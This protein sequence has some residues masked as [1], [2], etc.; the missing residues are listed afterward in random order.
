[1][2]KKEHLKSNVRKLAIKA[3]E[4]NTQEET[5]KI[6]NV[7]R[8]TIL[9]WKKKSETQDSLERKVGSGRSTIF[10][11]EKSTWLMSL[12]L[13]NATNHGFETD[14]WTTSRICQVYKK[15]FKEII[16][17]DT[18]QIVLKKLGFTYHKPEKRYYDNDELQ[19]KKNEWLENKLVLIHETASK[20]NAVVYY[21][22]EANISLSPVIGK[23]WAMKGTTPTISVTKNRGSI[24]AISAINSTGKLLFKLYDKKIT[25]IEIIYFLNQ[26]LDHHKK[27]HIVV[28]MD[29]A[30]SHK[31]K[32]VNA[33][34]ESQKR[35]HVIY[36]SP[37]SPEFN[38]DEKVWNHLKNHELK[39]H[40]AKTKGELKKLTKRKLENMAKNKNLVKGIFKRCYVA[41][42][43]R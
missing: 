25:S 39:A 32:K 38:P 10:N 14:L 37:Y 35:L 1:M 30:T 41:N 26:I 33:F 40:R 8:Y 19:K 17:D 12:V 42:I 36:F 22:D 2:K 11:E 24:S 13:S 29:N 20:Y 4:N 23:T 27:R 5:A 21:E 16:S 3:L 6:F 28:V 18:I 43:L 15:D 9:R 34:I 31:S 7:S